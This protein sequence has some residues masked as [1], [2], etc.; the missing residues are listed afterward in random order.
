MKQPT[1][2]TA[3]V[4]DGPSWVPT[5]AHTTHVGSKCPPSEVSRDLGSQSWRSAPFHTHQPSPVRH[6]HSSIA[7][8]TSTLHTGRQH[9]PNERKSTAKIDGLL[10]SRAKGRTRRIPECCGVHHSLEMR[11]ESR[12]GCDTRC[13]IQNRHASTPSRRYTLS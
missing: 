10:G 13:C 9:L 8:C 4:Y 11:K 2:A 5:S 7:I 3:N 6:I 12:A 1:T